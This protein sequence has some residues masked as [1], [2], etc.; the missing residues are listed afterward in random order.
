MSNRVSVIIDEEVVPV[1]SALGQRSELSVSLMRCCILQA[2]FPL[3][4]ALVVAVLVLFDAH[5]YTERLG[6]GLT[7]LVWSI[8]VSTLVALY[9]GQ[10]FVLIKMKPRFPRLFIFLPLVGF[11]AMTVNTYL[12]TMHVSVYLPGRMSVRDVALHLPFNLAMGLIFETLFFLFV[13]PVLMRNA[14]ARS[15]PPISARRVIQVSGVDILAADIV[16]LR[17][18]DHYVEVVTNSGKTLVRARIRDFTEQLTEDEGITPHRS[19]WVAW[20]NIISAD[21]SLNYAAITMSD[22]SIVPVAKGRIKDFESGAKNFHV[23]DILA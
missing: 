2:N 17:A 22:G 5:G 15:R 12:T 8:S 14:K 23:E 21:L 3:F 6:V 7:V 9:V 20:Q 16:L 1:Y 13:K 10:I 18:Q 4:L 19:Y 11:V